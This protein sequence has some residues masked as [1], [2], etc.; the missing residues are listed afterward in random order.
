MTN[1]L[2]TSLRFI[3]LLFSLLVFHTA[4]AEEVPYPDKPNPPKLVN[5][6][7]HILG[8]AEAND[9]EQKLVSFDN[10]TSTQI[11]IVTVT[12]LGGQD[13]AEYTTT[14]FNRW[15]IGQANKNNGVLILMTLDDGYGK[16]RVFITVGKGLQ[17]VLTDAMTARIIRNEMIPEFKNK[18]YY[19]GLLNGAS[20]IIE[21]TKGEYKSDNEHAGKKHKKGV[22]IIALVIIFIVLIIIIKGR[23]NG[24]GGG[25]R[26]ISGGGAGDFMAGWIIGNMLN[27]GNRGGGFG[28]GDS[29]GFGGF[30][31]FGGGSS[32]G[33]GAGG[34]WD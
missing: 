20:S 15:G 6:F 5:D 31:G 8:S 26:Y 12:N 24:R 7:A 22:P 2:N 29:G 11:S 23:N 16:K 1:I 3:V 33:G 19:Q 32:D 30:G 21:V 34:S 28:G 4:I 17:G 13:I 18:N 10:T 25:G 9:L 14:L 27:G